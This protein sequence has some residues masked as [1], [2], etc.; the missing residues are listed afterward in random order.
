MF[1][2]LKKGIKMNYVDFIPL[3]NEENTWDFDNSNKIIIKIKNKGI[4]NSLAVKF[5]NKP[6]VC[7]I[8][9]DR[10]GSFV[11]Q[12]INGQN[13]IQDIIEEIIETFEEERIL[14]TKRTVMFFEMLRMNSLIKYK[15]LVD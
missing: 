1:K 7:E 12:Q 15:K 3:I 6:E 14:A 4:V 8:E 9:L 11:W 2:R 10:Y 5:L 13:T